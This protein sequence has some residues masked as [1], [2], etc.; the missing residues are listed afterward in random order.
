MKIECKSNIIFI[1]CVWILSVAS[2][3]LHAQYSFPPQTG[4][5]SLAIG[6]AGVGGLQDTFTGLLNPASV[7]KVTD[8]RVSVFSIFAMENRTITD[9][10][11]KD[12]P[13][14]NSE[15]RISVLPNLGSILNFGSSRFSMGIYARTIDANRL[16]FSKDSLVRYHLRDFRFSSSAFDV[17]FGVIP[18]N[19]FAFG[20]NVGYL[21]GNGSFSRYD[22]PMINDPNPPSNLDIKWDIDYKDVAELMV[23]AGALWSPNYR[24]DLGM[25]IRPPAAYHFKS[26]LSVKVPESL[27]GMTY[28]TDLEKLRITIPASIQL[29]THFIATDRIDVFADLAWNQLS[30]IDDINLTMERPRSPFI[31]QTYKYKMDLKDRWSVHLGAELMVSDQMTLRAGLF[32]ATESSDPETS[33][34]IW[35]IPQQTGVSVGVNFRLLGWDAELSAS[36]VISESTRNNLAEDVTLPALPISNVDVSGDSTIIGIGLSRSF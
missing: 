5:R 2:P 18:L 21:T 35:A 11:S 10:S 36:H 33:S 20:L 19:D 9:G 14:T 6:G 25:T 7:A 17:A 8:T 12:F 13:E 32:H 23:S 16:A 24:F 4:L 22:N 3:Y 1:I 26:E 28:K 27:G 29:G 30:Q 15:D 34:V 31:P